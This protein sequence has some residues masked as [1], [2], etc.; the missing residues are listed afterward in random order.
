[1]RTTLRR[2]LL[3][4]LLAA[5]G[6]GLAH[7]QTSGTMP[8]MPGMTQAPAASGDTA[9]TT[10]YRAAMATMM[11]G[12]DITYSGNAD[13]DFVVGMI[14]H[15]QGAIDMAKVELQYGHDPALQK[16]AREIV[17]AQEKEIA[18]MRGWL[19]KHP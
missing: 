7:A 16:L 6:V 12:M 17:A 4:A 19:A 5:G 9:A 13:R 10:A 11:R 18:F 2:A 1:M 8:G 14:P 15:H 3:A